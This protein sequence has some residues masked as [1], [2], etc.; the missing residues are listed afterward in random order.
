MHLD[1]WEAS[2]LHIN[3]HRPIQAPT[4]DAGPLG[5]RC[6]RASLTL[7]KVKEPIY[8]LSHPFNMCLWK[9]HAWQA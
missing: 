6:K 8:S 5:R 7:Q 3:V 1:V 2:C 9:D 4:R